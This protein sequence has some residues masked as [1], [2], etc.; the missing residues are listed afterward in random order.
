MY[1]IYLYSNNVHSKSSNQ[2]GYWTGKSYTV[3]GEGYPVCENSTYKRKEYKSLQRSIYAGEIATKKYGYVCGFDIEDEN[4]NIV[5]KS[6]REDY[7]KIENNNKSELDDEITERR[8]VK[9][10]CCGKLIYEGD[11]CLQHKLGMIYCSYKCLVEHG[12][13]GYYKKFDLDKN[14][15]DE[16]E[17]DFENRL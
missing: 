5:Y 16:Y 7:N 1:Y 11:F 13:C 15:I 2:Y 3:E 4:G 10:K 17:E 9:C 14:K 12:F 6:N 8:Y